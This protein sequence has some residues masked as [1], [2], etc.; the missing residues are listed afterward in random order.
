VND[1]TYHINHFT[2]CKYQIN[3]DIQNTN[4]LCGYNAGILLNIG[5]QLNDGRGFVNYLDVCY[6]KSKASPVYTKHKIYGAAIKGAMKSN[7]RP[8]N[9]KTAEVP[10]SVSPADAFTKAKQ[11]KRFEIILGKQANRYFEGGAFLARGHL[12]PDADGIFTSWQTATYY[13]VNVIPQWQSINNGN[14][15]AIESAVRAKAAA[16]EE[17]VIVYTGGHGIL[18]LNNKNIQ[19]DPKGLEVPMWSWKIIKVESINSGI[20]F[21]T[22]NNPFVTADPEPLCRD[23]CQEHNWHFANKNNYEKGFTICC[24][25]N[26]LAAVVPG[27]PEE[28]RVANVLNK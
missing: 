12:S 25:V 18:K 5:F 24:S 9:F 11:M 21:V 28:A 19:L 3:G 17:E 7:S 16:M 10:S 23:I 27:I 15:K 20:A 26:Y 2:E 6:N 4:T 22:Y 8:S 14:W 13:Y 1:A